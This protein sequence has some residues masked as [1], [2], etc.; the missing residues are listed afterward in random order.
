MGRGRPRAAR[1]RKAGRVGGKEI[2]TCR[3]R[4]EKGACLLAVELV[5][6]GEQ[7]VAVDAKVCLD[8]AACYLFCP[9]N[10][11]LDSTDYAA[12]IS[13]TATSERDPAFLFTRRGDPACLGGIMKRLSMVLALAVWTAGGCAACFADGGLLSC[14]HDCFYGKSCACGD[15]CPCG[16]ACSG[17][18]CDSCNAGCGGRRGCGGGLCE[19]GGLCDCIVSDCPV[20]QGAR[21][22]GLFQRYC[23][24]EGC[25]NDCGMRN[26]YDCSACQ[27]RGHCYGYGVANHS[28]CGCGGCGDGGCGNGGGCGGCGNGGCGCGPCAY[29]CGGGPMYGSGCCAGPGCCA[30][31]DQHYTF[32]P[33]P[34]VGQTAYPYYTTRGPRDFL[35][36]NPAPIGPY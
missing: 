8:S 25:C 11:F 29:G 6:Y 15:S 1:R 4:D 36:K 19:T 12:D 30:S 33:G 21:N 3:R 7:A 35:E 34:P 9:A 10:D 32:N 20:C 16:D 27:L 13:F 24:P 5:G 31:G 17:G 23:S 26:D 22:C 14:L 18:C 2:R 28:C